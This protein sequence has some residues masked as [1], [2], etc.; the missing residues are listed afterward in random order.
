MYIVNG[1]H[2]A[3]LVV[4]EVMGLMHTEI[5]AIV[6]MQYIRFAP[7]HPTASEMLVEV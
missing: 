3:I 7:R 1:T 5:A 4:W 6:C 2:S